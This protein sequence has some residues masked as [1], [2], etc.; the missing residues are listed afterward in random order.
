M[1]EYPKWKSLLWQAVFI[2]IAL[3]AVVTVFFKEP[4]ERQRQT[5]SLGGYQQ[6]V[7]DAKSY[8]Y[9]E[10]GGEFGENYDCQA[11]MIDKW[12]SNR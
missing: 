6:L 2:Y 5:R 10:L 4:K 9:D 3:G 12:S 1:S 11:E 8:C 7:I